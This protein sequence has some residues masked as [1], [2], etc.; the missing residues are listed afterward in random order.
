M[1]KIGYP[2]FILVMILFSCHYQQPKET[3]S[4]KQQETFYYNDGNDDRSHDA[5]YYLSKGYQVFPEFDLAIKS[6]CQLTDQSLQSSANHDFIMGC[7]VNEHSNRDME[8]YQVIIN[9]L[10][11]GYRD[12]NKTEQK[13]FEAEMLDKLADGGSK[14]VVFYDSISGKVFDFTQNGY[15]ARALVF[16]W[17]GKTYGFTLI[18]NNELD[19]N[20]NKWTNKIELLKAV[21]IASV[22]SQDKK[23]MIEKKEIPSDWNTFSH[24]LF[25]IAYPPKWEEF[26]T[27]YEKTVLAVMSPYVDDFT[28]R[29]NLNIIISNENRSFDKIWESL[30]KQMRRMPGYKVLQRTDF[31]L[32]GVAG[33][34]TEYNALLNDFYLRSVTYEFL[35]KGK[36][37]TMTFATDDRFYDRQKHQ[38]ENIVKSLTLK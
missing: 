22:M 20:F 15:S 11:L 3:T 19:K 30:S 36:L 38:I 29:Q 31:I 9:K 28:F 25:D 35:I 24:P 23:G 10:P 33:K 34:R 18:T 27:G 26:D 12:L 7:F 4:E 17:N 14:D 5:N 16:I 13:D 21:K 37:I 8:F 6:P 1:K 2:L 32:D